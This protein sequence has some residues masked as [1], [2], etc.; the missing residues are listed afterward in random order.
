MQAIVSV[1]GVS[2]C[3]HGAHSTACM[4]SGVARTELG[5]SEVTIAASHKP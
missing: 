5:G 2:W 4:A 3:K 1:H